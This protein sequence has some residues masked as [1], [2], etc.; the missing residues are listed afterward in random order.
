MKTNEALIILGLNGQINSKDI[1]LAYK[2]KAAE[3]HPDRNP[4]GEEMMKIINSAY[5]VVKGIDT[6]SI[7]VDEVIT[8]YPSELDEAI[9]MVINLD[10]IKIEVC[11]LWVWLSGKTKEHKAVLKT[12]GFKYAS[13]KKQWYF[14][15]DKKYCLNKGKTWDMN[16]IR[17]TY[18]SANAEKP[19]ETKKIQ[20]A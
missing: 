10:G 15:P 17:S 18:G 3:Y 11:G 16:K 12:A 19:G 13:K 1:K 6:F 20:A 4:A 5:D 14:R 9:N 8:S 7:D 2:R